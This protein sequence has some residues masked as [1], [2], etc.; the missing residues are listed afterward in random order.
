M[1]S[2]LRL[3]SADNSRSLPETRLILKVLAQRLA[4]NEETGAEY[5]MRSHWR[6]QHC[7]FLDESESY[8]CRWAQPLYGIFCL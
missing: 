1:I 7:D 6:G 8:F 2:G 3:R 4:T 5:L